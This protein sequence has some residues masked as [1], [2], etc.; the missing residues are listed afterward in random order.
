MG[1]FVA[2]FLPF[3]S[4]FCFTLNLPKPDINTSSPDSSFDLMISSR[5]STVSLACFFVRSRWLFNLDTMLAF[6]S[7]MVDAPFGEI[8]FKLHV[9]Y[10]LTFTGRFCQE[11][12]YVNGCL[13]VRGLPKRR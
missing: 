7:D 8:D 10:V 3:R 4:A 6:V 1:S 5:V 12:K 11:I 2:G 13:Y 9:F